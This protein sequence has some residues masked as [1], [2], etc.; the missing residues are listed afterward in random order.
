MHQIDQLTITHTGVTTFTAT[1]RTLKPITVTITCPQGLAAGTDLRVSMSTFHSYTT[2]WQLDGVTVAAGTGRIVVGHE[3]PRDWTERVRGGVG[4]AGGGLVGRPINE[5]HLVVFQVTE[6][7]SSGAQIVVALRANSSI[8]A[9]IAGALLVKVRAPGDEPFTP[10]DQPIPLQN[11]AGPATRLEVRATASPD[12]EGRHRVVIF[13]GDELLNPA[14]TYVGTL[15]L[16]ADGPV[17]GL[18]DQILLPPTTQGRAQLDEVELADT[19]AAPT[20]V[21][22]T[23][24]DAAKGLTA[25]SN[26]I[27]ATPL[28]KLNH[29]F[30]AIHFH[31][32]LSVDGDRDPRAAYAYA[33]D[34]LNLD[35]VA[36]TDHAPIGAGW[37]EALAVN[38][39]FYAPGRFVTLP[40]WE[41]SNAYGHANLYLRTPASKTGPW[42]WNPEVN[43]SEVSWPDDVVMV[44]HHTNTGQPIARG[45]HKEAWRQGRYWAKYDWLIPN[46]RARLVEVVQGRSNFEADALDSEWGIVMGEQGASVQNALAMGW[47]LGFVAG[48]DNHEGHPTQRHGRYVG[49]TCFRAAELT[50]DAIW[51]AMDQRQTYATSGV[52]IVCDFTVNGLPAGHEGTV[53][54]GEPIHFSARLYGTAPIAVVEIIADGC[55]IWQAQPNRWDVELDAV[56]LPTP[57]G[58]WGYYYLRL[59]QADGHRAWLSPVWLTREE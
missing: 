1:D 50:R 58:P 44:P 37:E 41:S 15:T 22:I 52:P 7:L 3:L 19:L 29:Y 28:G 36:M 45:E 53:P 21:R 10:V 42:Y 32:R 11:Q 47:R 13:A 9:A 24:E 43:P 27:L 16:H 35:V 17:I 8:H 48:T 18:P 46:P 59:R 34:I 40:A 5:V 4:P 55:T 23:V 51:Q 33:R 38:E 56:P 20:A 26:P 49:M 39:E 2:D 12:A 14:P 30:G 25:T 54:A 57:I 31:T 6:P